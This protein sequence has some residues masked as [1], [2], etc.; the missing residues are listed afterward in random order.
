MTV[1]H[2]T[3]AFRFIQADWTTFGSSSLDEALQK[4]EP[5]S[6]I[7]TNYD[8]FQ[9]AVQKFSRKCIPR[10]YNKRIMRLAF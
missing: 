9:G 8:T 6:I 2:I 5:V 4:L 3:S 10:G 1:L 7:P